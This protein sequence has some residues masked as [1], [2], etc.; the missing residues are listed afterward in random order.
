VTKGLWIG[1]EGMHN[2]LAKLSRMFVSDLDQDVPGA[3]PHYDRRNFRAKR[4]APHLELV[5]A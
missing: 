4:L 2:P 3:Q 5:L 1:L